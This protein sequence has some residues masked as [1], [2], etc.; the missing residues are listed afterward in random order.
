[1]QCFNIKSTALILLFKNA[2]NRPVFKTTALS[3]GIFERILFLAPEND[4]NKQIKA[5]KQASMIKVLCVK[6]T[7][8]IP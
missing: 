7:G 1:M 4:K 5:N 8:Q 3:Y 2:E 6:I